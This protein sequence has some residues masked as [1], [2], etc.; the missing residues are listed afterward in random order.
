MRNRAEAIQTIG[1]YH[2]VELIGKGG[3][4]TVYK[5]YDPLIKRFVAIKTCNTDDA[6]FRERF[7]REAEITGRLDHPNI[8]RI[9]DLGIEDDTPYLVQ[10]YLAGED[11]DRKIER[12]DYLPDAEKILYLIQ[13]ARG[14]EFAHQQGVI[15]RDIK[16]ANIRVLEDGSAKI[17]DFGI[18]RLRHLDNSLTQAGLTVGTAAYL[19]PEQ[20]HGNP[21]SPQTDIFSYGVLAYE[22]LTGERP[23]GRETISATFF[24]ILNREPRPIPAFW[25][26][27]PRQAVTLI[28]RC[29]QKD[30]EKRYRDC[31]QLLAQLESIREE[32]RSRR[33]ERV[34]ADVTRPIDR[35]EVLTMPIEGVVAEA[36]LDDLEL[37]ATAPTPRS[38][39]VATRSRPSRAWPLLLVLL[40][41]AAIAGW[42]YPDRV[43][44]AF[45][46]IL[47]SVDQPVGE[48]PIPS[49]RAEPLVT[50]PPEPPAAADPE[51]APS[52]AP[53]PPPVAAPRT[54]IGDAVPEPAAAAAIEPKPPPAPAKATLIVPAGWSPGL[55]ASIDGGPAVSL[56]QT[57]M[58]ALEPGSHT[59]TFSLLTRRYRAMESVEVTLSP[60]ERR[61]LDVPFPQPGMLTVQAALG[62][63]Q[64]RVQL[65]DEVP[66]P[67]PLRRH[68]LAPG[69]YRLRILDGDGA[70]AT[71]SGLEIRA[72]AETVVT[73]DL[74]RDGD[75]TV[76]R[77]SIVQ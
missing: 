65:N 57:R 53:E 46:T 24:A 52:P 44:A 40:T 4:G 74:D 67:S 17:M 29:L 48:N 56:T 59:V 33:F 13:I 1:K 30:A 64:G 23:F 15:H 45:A 60:G 69:S 51:P 49:V 43:S 12:R 5:G 71:S 58:R 8:V 54:E 25:P 63:R 6:E 55:K 31:G 75:L 39:A 62:S 3:Y 72:G 21:A 73:F 41:L 37:A 70:P 19:A 68:L 16:P 38:G 14:L 76:R 20:V 2:V 47:E 9:Y 26:D 34:S 32:L 10:E 36:S 50:T 66:V 77:R 61:V 11:L 35:R 42:R 7:F 27:C 28:H 18:A 22:L